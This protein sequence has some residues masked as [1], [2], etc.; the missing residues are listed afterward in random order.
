MRGGGKEGERDVRCQTPSGASQTVHVCRRDH[1]VVR[2]VRRRFF[3]AHRSLDC[4]NVGSSKDVA[5]PLALRAAAFCRFLC[6]FGQ[7]GVVVALPRYHML[8]FSGGER[9][10]NEG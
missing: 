3:C 10:T 4:R 5:R 1:R 8:P 6:L 7:M 2:Q 9:E